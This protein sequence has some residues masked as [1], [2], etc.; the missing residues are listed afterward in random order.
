MAVVAV[1]HWLGMVAV[2]D[3]GELVGG[4]LLDFS[5]EY[6][7]ITWIGQVM[8]LFFFV[9]GFA[10]AT[11]LRSAERKGVRPADWIATRLHR[12]VTPAAALAALLGRHPGRRDRARR[13]RGR[14]HRRRRRGHPA[15]V[16]RQLHDRHRPGAVHLPLVPGP[17]A[18]ARGRAGRALRPRRGGP[19]RRHPGRPPAELG[20]RLARLP[21]RRLRLAGRP[22]AHRPPP[23]RPGGHVLGAG[24]GRGHPRAV[25]RGDAAPRRPR[26]QPDPPPVDR[27]DPVRPGLLLHRRRPR[28]GGDPLAGAV[29][30]GLAD[31][32]RRQRGGHVGVPVAHDRC[33]RGRRGGLRPRACSPRSRRG[34]PRGGGPRSRSCS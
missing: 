31:H 2:L 30:P 32:R 15:L 22:A 6:G 34:P 8:P 18:P 16:P 25:A 10:S 29:G 1:G 27:P 3:R 11:S 12:M 20:H 26:A 23:R 7:W 13:V 4:N 21:G 19:L 24:P 17:A 5:P 9:G 28:P 33:G 14:R